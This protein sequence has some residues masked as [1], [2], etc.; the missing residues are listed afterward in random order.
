MTDDAVEW[1]FAA[2]SLAAAV[3]R[4]DGQNVIVDQTGRTITLMRDGEIA[5]KIIVRPTE[6]GGP[7]FM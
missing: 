2:L 5:A 3:A 7:Q 1:V 6:S 4:R